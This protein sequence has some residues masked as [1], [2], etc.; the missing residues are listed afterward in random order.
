[1]PDEIPPDQRVF[2]Y[3]AYH[4]PETGEYYTI[5]NPETGLWYGE[6]IPAVFIEGIPSAGAGKGGTTIRMRK[7]R[8]KR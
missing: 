8:A 6:K 4:N 2:Y 5:R 7:L 3:R 1:M